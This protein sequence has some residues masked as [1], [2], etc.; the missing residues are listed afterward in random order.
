[1]EQIPEKTA[2]CLDIGC[3]KGEL[4][5]LAAEK[6]EK[7]VAVDLSEKMIGYARDHHS[8]DNIDYICGNVLDL[9]FDDESL[10]VIVT[11]ATAHH[12]PDGWLTKFAVRTLRKGG[13]L[14]V[15]DL[16]K[17]STPA[18]YVVWGAAF[19]PNIVMSLIK[20]GRLRKDDPHT[21][22][23]WRAHGRHDTYVTL[24]EIRQTASRH[25]PGAVVRR[26]LFWRYTLVWEKK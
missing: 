2:V 7:V 25:L 6:S 24:R 14:L 23:I 20:N 9:R 15:L 19:L 22:E 11:T 18:D 17:A 8:R 13:K 10:D 21:A 26:R 3:G 16:A 5:T 4:T 12:L 1:V